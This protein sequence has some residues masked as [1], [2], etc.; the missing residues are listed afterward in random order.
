[1][2]L[3]L[4]NH[5]CGKCNQAFDNYSELRKHV[6]AQHLDLKKCAVCDYTSKKKFMVLRH[7]EQVHG[8]NAVNCTV[9]GCNMVLQNEVNL[10]V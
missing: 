1:M 10:A 5:K 2:A 3:N 9:P 7:E 4:E 6:T 8:D